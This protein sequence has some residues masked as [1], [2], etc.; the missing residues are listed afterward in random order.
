MACFLCAQASWA[1]F[2]QKWVSQFGAVLN[3]LRTAFIVTAMGWG[4]RVFNHDSTR[5]VLRPI[6]RML[7]KVRRDT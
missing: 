7:K 2:E 4:I 1:V 5:L 6:E 3:L